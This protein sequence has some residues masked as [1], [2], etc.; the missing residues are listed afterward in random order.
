MFRHNNKKK[1]QIA[2]SKSVWTSKLAAV[3]VTQT[4]RWTPK[5]FVNNAN[6]CYCCYFKQYL[7]HF[8]SNQIIIHND[9]DIVFGKFL[10]NF[11]PSLPPPLIFF[12]IIL[13]SASKIFLFLS[14]W[15]VFDLIFLFGKWNFSLG[16]WF[17]FD[18]SFWAN[19]PFWFD[20]FWSLRNLFDEILREIWNYLTISHND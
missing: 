14:K 4:Q 9:F 6:Y 17:W 18:F 19:G 3:S 13:V 10:A 20:L 7:H 8:A 12:F 5:S 2:P 15:S 16:K 1:I 11:P